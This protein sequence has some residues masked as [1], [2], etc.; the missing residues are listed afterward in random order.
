MLIGF[1]LGNLKEKTLGKTRRSWKMMIK[2]IFKE[3]KRMEWSGFF[4]LRIGSS[5]N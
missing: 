5:G 4:W 3:H 1:W 2:Y